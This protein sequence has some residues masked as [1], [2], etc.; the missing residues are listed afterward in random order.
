MSTLKTIKNQKGFTLVEVIVVAVI[1]AALAGVAIPMYA[2]YVN[3]SRSNAAANAA[4]SV[5]SYM[6]ACI[7]QRETVT[8]TG[9][10]DGTTASSLSCSTTPATTMQLPIGI[11]FTISSYTAS[12]TVTAFHNGGG[13]TATYNY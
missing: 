10:M 6:G 1:V 4:G 11:T 7:N 8:P 9:A 13:D 5:A 12:G 2:G 3:S